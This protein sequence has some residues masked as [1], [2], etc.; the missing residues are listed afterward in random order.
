M[1]LRQFCLASLFAV[2]AAPCIAQTDEIQVYDA[3][4]A[5]PGVFNLTLHDNYTPIGRSEP[6]FPGGIVP[7]HTLNGVAE[8]AYGVTDW[9]EGGLYLPLYSV[10]SN[11]GPVLN[12]FKLRALFV[13]PDAAD[14]MFFYGINFEFSYNARHWDANRYTSEIRPIVGWHLGAL[15]LIFNP[16]FDN[17]YQGVSRL[18]FAPATRVAWNLSKSWAVAA[19]EYDDF[20][21]VRQLF[22][23]SAQSHQL[24]AVADWKGDTLAIEGGIGFGLTPAADDLV[25]KLILSKDLN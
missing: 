8:W 2:G 11:L 10:A 19:E 23:G 21:P 9:F 24:F 16:I 22:S 4:I 15:D 3:G 14:R 25:F 17:S 7:D 12:G 1:R 13:S 20:G 18:D 6:E 5:A